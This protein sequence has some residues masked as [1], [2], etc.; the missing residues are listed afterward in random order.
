MI[1]KIIHYCWLSNDPIPEEL[2]ECMASWKKYLPDY[3]FMKW[4]LNRFDK[5]SC[6]WV[7]EAFDAKK[8]AFAADYIRIYAL[9]NYGG[10]YLDM[11]VEVL[12][13][14]DDLLQLPYFLCY[15]QD[16]TGPEVAAFGAQEG[17]QW[18][19]DWL[20]YYKGRHFVNKDGSINPQNRTTLP[21]I[22]INWL[23]QRGYTFKDIIRP[24][25]ITSSNSNTICLLPS[26]YFSPK[27]YTDGKIYCT[28]NTYSIHHFAGS[29]I[30]KEQKIEHLFWHFLGVKPHRIMWHV[31]NWIDRLR[32]IIKRKR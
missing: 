26:E 20:A 28:P 31:D 16:A 24:S 3:E 27:S 29:W 11:D 1:P 18:L 25:E 23:G 4:D 13:S 19:A 30:P 15:E 14:F 12:K 21:K 32:H 5:E 9:Y 10:I 8:Y 6:P 2:Q 22:A 17:Q 7:S